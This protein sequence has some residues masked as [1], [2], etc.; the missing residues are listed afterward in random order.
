MR[1]FLVILVLGAMAGCNADR[2]QKLE[3]KTAELQ[4]QSS[5]LAAEKRTAEAKVKTC[6]TFL[7]VE[8]KHAEERR[9]IMR[10]QQKLL[11]ELSAKR[12]KKPTKPRKPTAHRRRRRKAPR[13]SARAAGVPKRPSSGSARLV[14]TAQG[15][16]RIS[17]RRETIPD[18]RR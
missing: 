14:R 12:G 10:D 15:W 9:Q 17:V 13:R 5:L 1:A 8:K 11:Q 2:L 6:E 7:S 4:T 16:F 18:A 3:R